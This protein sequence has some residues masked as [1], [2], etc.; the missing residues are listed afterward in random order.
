M[1]PRNKIAPY[2]P[3]LLVALLRF[4][5]AMEM[6]AFIAVVMPHAWMAAAHQWL[7]LGVLPDFPLLDY[8][9]RSA[10][11][12]YGLH[13][14]LLWMLAKDTKRFRPLIIYAAASYLA[15]VLVFAMIDLRDGMPWWW[16]GA[17]IASVLSYGLVLAWLLWD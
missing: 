11:F 5:G 1:N 8:M 17:E 15:S 12:L 13:G 6:L 9:I 7:G 4:E 14:V 10:S 2:K 3:R 16:T